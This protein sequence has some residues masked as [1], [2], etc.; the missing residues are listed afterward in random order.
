[1]SLIRRVVGRLRALRYRY[2]GRSN[3]SYWTAHNVSEHR[4]FRT[5]EE[6]H[7]FL[8]WRNSQ[9]LFYEEL[10]PYDELDG[11]VVADFGCGPGHDLVAIAERSSPARLIGLDISPSSLDEARAR[12][13]LHGI[14]EP[15]L[16][17]LDE[18]GTSL[19]LADASVDLILSSGVLHHI[20]DPEPTL[21][22]L[23]RVLR[24]GGRVRVMVYN[25]DSVWVHLY[26]PH[27]CQLVRGTDRKMALDDA[28]RR[29]TDG[30]NCP[31]S[32]AYRPDDFVAL[33]QRFGFEA[34]AFGAA[35]SALEMNQLP[36]RFDAI[37]NQALAPEHRQFLVGL[38]FDEHGRPLHDGR[39]AG[40]GGFFEL[41][42]P[43]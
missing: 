34:R 17:L 7:E 31:H 9:Y 8:E 12:L 40:I 42:K 1:V 29:S 15:E 28:F 2:A 20:V 5:R 16:L 37:K 11:L 43:G 19:P 22:E 23:H 13:A 3:T 30:A 26:V 21:Q 41:R 14:A 18:D 6:S 36:T 33:A 38:T 10:I 35:V 27:T 24:P 4:R 32:V 25:R 39:V